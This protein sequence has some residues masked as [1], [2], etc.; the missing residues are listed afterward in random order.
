MIGHQMELLDESSN[1]HKINVQDLKITYWAD[2]LV[3]YLSEEAAWL[4]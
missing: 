1:T 4:C 2:E 3:R